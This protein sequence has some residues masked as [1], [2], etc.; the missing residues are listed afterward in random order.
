L[1]TEIFDLRFDF[2]LGAAIADALYPLLKLM[3]LQKTGMHF[4]EPNT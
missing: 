4:S 3:H 2:F 1:E